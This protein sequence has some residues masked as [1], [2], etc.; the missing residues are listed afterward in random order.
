MKPMKSLFFTR[1]E[2]G[3]V[4]P[5]AAVLLGDT[6]DAGGLAHAIVEGMTAS[7]ST[8]KKTEL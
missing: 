4:A 8:I 3:E 5:E 7:M 6:C 2:T 1:T